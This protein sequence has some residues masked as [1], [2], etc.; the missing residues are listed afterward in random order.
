MSKVS[1]RDLKVIE[2]SLTKVFEVFNINGFGVAPNEERG[3]VCGYELDGFTGGGVN[4]G[5]FLDFRNK[6]MS[7]FNVVDIAAELE[8]YIDDFDIDETID[9]YREGESYKKAF[10]I[11]QSLEDFEAYV[12]TLN[13]M[14]DE[15]EKVASE[16]SDKLDGIDFD[17]V[18]LTK[19]QV[20]ELICGE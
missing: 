10:S 6:G 14:F 9:L 3:V 7:A 19:E 4:T 11:R 1:K 20:E 16:Y 5:P 12:K 2:E 18:S 8:S 17:K 15:A 13:K